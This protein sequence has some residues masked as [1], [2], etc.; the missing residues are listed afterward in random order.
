MKLPFKVTY[1]DG[2]EELVTALPRD[3]I[4]FERRYNVPYSQL[5]VG[6]REEWWFWLAWSPLNRAGRDTRDFEGFIN[7]I[8]GVEL[9]TDEESVA[10]PF[11]K[12][13]SDEQSP[14]S[15]PQE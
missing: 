14:P 10:G 15:P 2:R 5:S 3:V 13:P 8:V 6:G 4:E 1:D 11:G 7:S 9:V 12:A